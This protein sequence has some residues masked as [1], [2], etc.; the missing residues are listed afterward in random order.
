[1]EKPP[2]SF[3]EIRQKAQKAAKWW[4]M[5]FILPSELINEAVDG[6]G[7]DDL[8]SKLL[9]TTEEESI[10]NIQAEKLRLFEKILTDFLI[11]KITEGTD[12]NLSIDYQPYGEMDRIINES[13]MN[14]IVWP[15]KAEMRIQGG[16][17]FV[18]G[19]Y[20]NGINLKEL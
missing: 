19:N 3:E 13:G 14:S 2:T 4:V 20:G 1:M 7:L 9:K 16:K 15:F 11:A 18:D 5:K 17:V 10:D 12:V 6:A 8:N